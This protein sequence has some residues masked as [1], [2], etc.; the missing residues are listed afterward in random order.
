VTVVTVNVTVAV[1]DRE[2]LDPVIVTIFVPVDVNVHESVAVPDPVTVAELKE[3][4]ELSAER[5]TIP[6]NW[7][8]SV[9]VIV[10]YPA[11]FAFTGTVAG[12]AEIVNPI[13][14]NR[15]VAVV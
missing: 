5:L 1:E 10:E 13:T 6:L 9:T 3:Q 2:P 14:W 4:A 7:L 12:L 15:T 11:V 8:T